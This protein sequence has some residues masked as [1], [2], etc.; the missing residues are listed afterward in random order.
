MITNIEKAFYEMARKDDIKR[1]NADLE[2]YFFTYYSQKLTLFNHIY[3][4]METELRDYPD[5]SSGHVNRIMGILGKMLKKHVLYLDPLYLDQS[6]DYEMFSPQKREIFNF[7]EVYLLLC[8]TILHDIGNIMARERHEERIK[9]VVEKVELFF[10]DEDVKKYALWI[11][12]AHR[13]ENSISSIVPSNVDYRNEEIN[14]RFLAAVLKLADELEEGEV[15]IDKIYYETRKTKISEDKKLHWN[16][17]RCIKRINPKPDAHI[18]DIRAEMQDENTC[19][20]TYPKK[21]GESIRSV[22]LIDELISRIDKIN[23]TRKYYMQF[24]TKYIPFDSIDF[25]LK[26]GQ[27]SPSY[28]LTFDNTNGY[29]AFWNIYPHLNPAGRIKDYELQLEEQQ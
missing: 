13:G 16:I 5:H 15:R 18:I 24:I 29:H 4:H 1:G 21:I 12:Q 25:K 10:V 20:A 9:Q 8:A 19:F 11:A 28:S 23:E 22:A 7:F 14:L 17:S 3:S 26:I 2:E 27:T 6:R